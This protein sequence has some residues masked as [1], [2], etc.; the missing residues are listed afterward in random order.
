MGRG[1]G[2]NRT[3]KVC[4]SRCHGAKNNWCECWC[5]GL[6][7]GVMGKDARDALA[8]EVGDG[9]MQKMPDPT[10]IQAKDMGPSLLDAMTSAS[11]LHPPRVSL[12]AS[13][14]RRW[15]TLETDKGKA[16]REKKEATDAQPIAD[17]GS[18][19]A[20]AE[21]PGTDKDPPF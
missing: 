7:H 11:K 3:V 20:E 17:M 18:T 12:P 19:Q 13:A 21:G 16:R 6:F 14:T 5:S 10:D 2:G 9:V 4:D 1:D 8:K 15:V